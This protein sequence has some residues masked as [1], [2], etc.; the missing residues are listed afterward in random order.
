M[1]GNSRFGRGQG[2]FEIRWIAADDW[3]EMELTWNTKDI[4]LNSDA[5]V[6]VGMFSNLYFG[7]GYFPVQ[8]FGLSLPETLVSDIRSGDDVSLYL[9]AL[10]SSVGFTFNS[11]DITG[12][13]PPPCL[14]IVVVVYNKADLNHDGR[15]NFLDYAK[16]AGRWR[17]TGP[18]LDG[19]VN[20]DQIVDYK[21]L[22]TLA[23]NWLA[24]DP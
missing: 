4:Y 17:E 6:S 18:G 20:E 21:D 19:D 9:T 5:D 7:D 10:D 12:T 1:P 24:H 16:L 2:R 8:R 22:E 3:L 14:E 11:R 23:D 15:A 13:R